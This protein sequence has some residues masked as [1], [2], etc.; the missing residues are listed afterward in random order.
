MRKVLVGLALLLAAAPVAA[1]TTLIVSAAA[2]AVQ[3]STCGLVNNVTVTTVSASSDDG[4]Q[5]TTTM[6]IVRSTSNI[7]D[8]TNEYFAVRFASI[9]IPSGATITG[10]TVQFYFPSSADDEPNHTMFF[11]MSTNPA[12]L[13]TSASDI[14][15]RTPTTSSVTWANANLGAPGFFT[16]PN[17]ATQLSELYTAAGGV[18]NGARVVLMVRGSATATRDFA[19]N[20]YDVGI[21]SRMPMMT[22]T[23]TT[24]TACSGGGGPSFVS[25]DLNRADGPLGGSTSSSGA[26]WVAAAGG[27]NGNM[28]ITS[29]ATVPAVF[30]DDNGMIYLSSQ[31]TAANYTASSTMI[32][33]D[34]SKN[35]VMFLFALSATD[36][37]GCRWAGGNTAWEC[38]E[39]GT[40]EGA[41]TGGDE[42]TTSAAIS[43]VVTGST[44]V[45]KVNGNTK[46]SGSL[47]F[48]GVGLTGFYLYYNDS[49]SGE[50]WDEPKTTL[51]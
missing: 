35:T 49:G 12:T 51:D 29:N 31:T 18:F 26:P 7:I 36:W 6:D 14:S 37:A 9:T 47:G 42:P 46:Y 20:T 19:V 1:R 17:L 32:L 45:L 24:G 27:V 15:N 10:C 30:G 43:V 48:S 50:A 4:D 39:N 2:P 11:Q 5:L 28:T 40:L 44:Y 34:S 33:T 41:G 21:S 22:I 23:Y 3:S 8:A 16:S 13:S 25:D 38:Y